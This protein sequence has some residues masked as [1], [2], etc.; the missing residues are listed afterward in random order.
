MNTITMAQPAVASIKF[1]GLVRMID[2]VVGTLRTWNDRAK[3]RR[4][5][6]YL[7]DQ[8]LQDIGISRVEALYK[9]NKK[10]WEA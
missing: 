8:L 10:F 3:Q 4:Q 1:Y 9:Y 2:E 6:V 7:D 5:L